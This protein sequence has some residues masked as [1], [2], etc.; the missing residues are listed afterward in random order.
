[1]ISCGAHT[2]L[3]MC[4]SNYYISS[5]KS[6]N[7]I[8]TYINK[9]IFFLDFFIMKYFSTSTS[10]FSQY[11]IIV[12]A[13]CLINFTL[14]IKM[15]FSVISSLIFSFSPMQSHETCQNLQFLFSKILFLGYSWI[16]ENFKFWEYNF[17]HN[18]CSWSHFKSLGLHLFLKRW[19][20]WLIFH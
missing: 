2:P 1:M 10:F 3:C 4:M 17:F 13:P 14:G 7:I 11:I 8:L 18:G 16:V 19:F 9:Y 20:L 12:T 15:C 6:S 5:V